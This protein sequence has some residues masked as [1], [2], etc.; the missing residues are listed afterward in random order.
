MKHRERFISAP[1]SGKITAGQ[2]LAL[3]LTVGVGLW[4]GGVALLCWVF[5][6]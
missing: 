4:V 5:Y 6:R 2:A 1:P 3:L